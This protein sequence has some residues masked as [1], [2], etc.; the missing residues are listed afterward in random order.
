MVFIY[1]DV[2][3]IIRQNP[4]Q[5]ALDDPSLNVRGVG[6]GDLQR[7]LPTSTILSLFKI[8]IGLINIK[9]NKSNILAAMGK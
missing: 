3:N 6:F 7:F 5:L 8:T 1:G 9:C 4:G 2:Q